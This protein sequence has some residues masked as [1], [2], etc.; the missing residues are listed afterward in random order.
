MASYQENMHQASKTT[1][2]N[3]PSPSQW[4]FHPGLSCLLVLNALYPHALDPTTSLVE[5]PIVLH[6]HHER[7]QHGAFE[8]PAGGC[9]SLRTSRTRSSK[10]SWTL[11]CQFFK[12]KTG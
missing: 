10:A 7:E 8:S 1:E 4:P 5:L 11:A 9:C 2:C 12:K 3:L 6:F